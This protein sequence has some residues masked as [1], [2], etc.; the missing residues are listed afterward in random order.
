MD[1]NFSRQLVYIK[2]KNS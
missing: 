2:P 1:T